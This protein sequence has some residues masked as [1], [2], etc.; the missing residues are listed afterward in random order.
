MHLL[1]QIQGA[2]IAASAFEFVAGVAGVVGLLLRFI[3]PLAITPTIALIGLSL[4]PVA[5]EHAQ[6]NWPIAIA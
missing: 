6:S 5:A 1:L 4:Y 3:T 2:I